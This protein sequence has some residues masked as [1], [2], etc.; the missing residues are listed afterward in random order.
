M[1]TANGHLHIVGIGGTLRKQSSSR[2]ALE[3]ALQSAEA[4][5]A[6]T[7]LLALHDLKLPMYVPD[8]PLED[9]G[10]N[11]HRF[12]ESVRRADAMIWSTA[13][14]HGT[15]AAPT[16]NAIEFL[17]FLKQHDPPYLHGKV[18]GLIAVAG[19]DMAAVNAINAM[20][21]VVHALRGT[22]APLM[23]PIPN[24]RRVFDA[25]GKVIDEKWAL[26]LDQLGK[27]IVETAEKFQPR[28]QN[29]ALGL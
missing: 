14:Y 8:Q 1:A 12:L 25:Q 27:L 4:A 5:G 26:R 7:E 28:E 11:V 17:E 18:I 15:L 20:V 2:A 9:Y 21:H 16:K 6:S 22:V 10:H 29:I 3:H 13:A 24:A 19:G 23:V